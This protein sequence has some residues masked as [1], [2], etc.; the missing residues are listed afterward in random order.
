MINNFKYLNNK[1]TKLSLIVNN[2]TKK[3]SNKIGIKWIFKELKDYYFKNM[4]HCGCT[5]FIL[6]IFQL[7]FVH[8]YCANCGLHQYMHGRY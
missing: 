7:P 6:D 4:C 2:K 1:I 5:N 8:R 3:I